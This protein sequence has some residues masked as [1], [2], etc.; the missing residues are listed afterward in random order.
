[1]KYNVNLIKKKE[2]VEVTRSYFDIN[3]NS[4][5]TVSQ[6]KEKIAEIVK[7]PTDLQ[8]SNEKLLINGKEKDAAYQIQG[9]DKI[10]YSFSIK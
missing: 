2:N 9:R 6:I 8:P 7:L 1:M 5:L 10:E 3:S 4:E